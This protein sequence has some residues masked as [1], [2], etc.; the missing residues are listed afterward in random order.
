VRGPAA[1]RRDGQPGQPDR[2]VLSARGCDDGILIAVFDLQGSADL[3]VDDPDRIVAL[4]VDKLGFPPPA[5]RWVH[6]RPNLGYKAVH[7]RVNLDV[8]AAPTTVEVIGPGVYDR[9]RDPHNA[10]Y[11]AMQRGRPVK[12]HG[13]VVGTADIDAVAARLRGRGLPYRMLEPGE[14]LKYPILFPG[15][16]AD[17][18]TYDPSVDGGLFLELVALDAF[19]IPSAPRDQPAPRPGDLVRVSA[20]SWVV[21]DLDAALTALDRN[22]GWQPDAAVETVEERNCLRATFRPS[23]PASAAI[24]I[25]QPRSRHGDVGGFFAEYGAGPFAHCLGVND[26]VA[27]AD[28]LTARGVAHRVVEGEH[29]RAD[30]VLVDP[31]EL[32]GLRFELVGTD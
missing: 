13:N 26:L 29:G 7:C 28:R 1:R 22:I 23:M 2:V 14:H 25:V 5:E 12:T 6:D 9:S 4:L 20:R 3:L 27:A 30:R 24:E 11:F 31:R 15:A 18:I 32:D 10:A 8:A 16:T 17:P 21:A 19:R